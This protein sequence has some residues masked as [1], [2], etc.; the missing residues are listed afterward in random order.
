M[1]NQNILENKKILVVD[2]ETDILE[3]LKE[4]LYM[5]SVDTAA[6]FEEAVAHLRNNTY[7]AAVLDIMG[8]KGYDLLKITNKIDIP[9]LMLTAHALT[10]DNLKQS[11][12]QQADAYVPKDKLV[13]IS[14]YIADIL[15]ARQQ[16][17]KVHVTWFSLLKPV[18]DKIF[19]EGWRKKDRD[20]W[21]EFDEKQIAS[22][23][24]IQKME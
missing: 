22:R 10:P 5:C 6:T 8:V 12:E 16:G 7:D 15:T 11:I 18:F 19:G 21:D 20:F 2:D 3:T 17:K 13:D 14:L 9:S 4:L 23:D 24:D 1:D